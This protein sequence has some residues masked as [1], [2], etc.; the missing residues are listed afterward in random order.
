MHRAPLPEVLILC[1][2]AGERQRTERAKRT[3]A[4]LRTA[5]AAQRTIGPG[6]KQEMFVSILKFD[7]EVCRSAWKMSML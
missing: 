1:R 3:D 7:S 4:R 5:L 6:T 2:S